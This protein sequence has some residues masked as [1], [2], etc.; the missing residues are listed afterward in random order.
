MSIIVKRKRRGKGKG[1]PICEET[2]YVFQLPLLTQKKKKIAETRMFSY[3]KTTEPRAVPPVRSVFES[4][5]VLSESWI[6]LGISVRRD[7]SD[8]ISFSDREA[9]RFPE[10][11]AEI[12][13]KSP[14]E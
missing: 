2:E 1:G 6:R 8:V 14:E 7:R 13:L 4:L 3:S 12:P 5:N 11:R 10:L 9:D